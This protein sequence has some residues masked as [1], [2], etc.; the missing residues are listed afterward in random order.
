MYEDLKDNQ[1]YQK[2]SKAVNESGEVLTLD[3]LMRYWHLQDESRAKQR[4]KKPKYPHKVNGY[5][6][7]LGKQFKTINAAAEEFNVKP[8]LLYKQI[9]KYGCNDPRI[10][11]KPKPK[12]YYKS[13]S[14]PEKYIHIQDKYFKTWKNVAKYYDI[15][16]KVLY[17]RHHRYENNDP[18]LLAPVRPKI[19]VMNLQFSTWQEAG[20]YYDINPKLLYERAKKY[21]F[22]NPIILS[23]QRINKGITIQNKHFNTI[24][25]AANYF[26]ISAEA[27]KGRLPRY[28][29]N[30]PQLVKKVVKLK[31]PVTVNGK[32]F[33]SVRK[34]ADYYRVS[35]QLVMSRRHNNHMSY[36][37]PQ[38]FAPA[39]KIAK[40][41]IINGI[42][43]PSKNAAARH[44]GLTKDVFIRRLKKY[45]TNDP[46]LIAPTK[47]R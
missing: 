17:Q 45:D 19:N 29:K 37:D 18:R 27:L 24:Q 4:P 40:P 44:F 41:V 22:D 10:L 36:S 23:N 14:H 39:K 46:R 38:I 21:G 5:W 33:E 3:K 1:E 11:E 15:D 32:T 30:D 16:L 12:L 13:T 8:S 20:N 9:R 7:I 47:H 35:Y 42:H 26:N 34:A 43:F 28:N 31:K 25:E 2:L 6:T